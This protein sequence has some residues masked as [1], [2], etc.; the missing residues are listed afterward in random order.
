MDR[1]TVDAY[2]L[3]GPTV[4]PKKRVGNHVRVLRVYVCDRIA[5]RDARL[6]QHGPAGVAD[7]AN[8]R[9]AVHV[10]SIKGAVGN[11][12]G[13]PRANTGIV[14]GKT[15]RHFV[16]GSGKKGRKG[17]KEGRKEGRSV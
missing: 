6:P 10:R 5:A 9:L 15:E 13:S 2:R 11:E 1:R 17:G 7:G 12:R 4:V 3:N 14:V 8:R 16:G